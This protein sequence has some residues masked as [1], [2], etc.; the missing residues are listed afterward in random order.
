MRLVQFSNGEDVVHGLSAVLLEGEG[1]RRG[2]FGVL[3][4]QL[5]DWALEQEHTSKLQIKKKARR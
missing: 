5:V 2:I 1:E 4:N 3:L